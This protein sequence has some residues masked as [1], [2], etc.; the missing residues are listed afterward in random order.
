MKI[1]LMG[2]SFNPVHTAHIKAAI[3]VKDALLLDKVIFIPAYVSPFKTDKK[4]VLGEH[5]YNMLCLAAEEYPFF[6]I[7]DFELI[8]GG[9]SYTYITVEHFAEKYPD[10]EIYFIMGDEAYAQFDKWKYPDRIRAAAQ[11]CVV[12][13]DGSKTDGQEIYISIPPMVVSSTDIREKIARGEDVG[14]ILHPNVLS[15][16]KKHNLYEG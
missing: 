3:Y 16:I 6:E 9:V 7:S 4:Q 5:R 11:I 8:S 13:R 10:D 14:G 12:T 2:G 15:Y 1:G